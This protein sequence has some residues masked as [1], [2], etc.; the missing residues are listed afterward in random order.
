ME[1]ESISN[2]SNISPWIKLLQRC[3]TSFD[4]KPTIGDIALYWRCLSILGEQQSL[5]CGLYRCVLRILMR[6]FRVHTFKYLGGTSS[7]YQ[8]K[9]FWNA[10]FFRIIKS[11]PS[12]ICPLKSP[13]NEYMP[14]TYWG[15]LSQLPG[16]VYRVQ[17]LSE[18]KE[19]STF[20][21]HPLRKL[22]R[23]R[24]PLSDISWWLPRD[25]CAVPPRP[26]FGSLSWQRPSW[27]PLPNWVGVDLRVRRHLPQGFF[28]CGWKSGVLGRGAPAVRKARRERVWYGTAWLCRK[29]TTVT[30]LCCWAW[31]D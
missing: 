28:G 9:H 20:L 6:A 15:N 17:C 11:L 10:K 26:S 7:K 5:F 12:Q 31:R 13:L 16:G 8:P 24:F 21:T 25:G 23:Q 18:H 30:L 3:I 27:R 14:G 29:I 19:L 2:S 22:S 1:I 4:R